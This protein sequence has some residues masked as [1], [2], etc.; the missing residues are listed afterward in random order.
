MPMPGPLRLRALEFLPRT[1][2][3]LLARNDF[4]RPVVITVA[5]VRK[6]KMTIHQVADV[7]AVGHS[8]VAAVGT[9]DVASFVTFAVVSRRA[10]GGIGFIDLQGM[11]FDGTTALVVEMS[12]VKI[13][14]MI[15]VTNGG[16]AAVL[17][18][19]VIVIFVTVTHDFLTSVRVLE[20][21]RGPSAPDRRHAD[22]GGNSKCAFP[23]VAAQSS[24]RC[25]IP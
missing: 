10:S 11:L 18:V 21:A 6:V 13:I 2:R 14:D 22:P 7:V 24:A 17:A 19:L 1:G 25:A 16:V 9:V 20:R 23:A 4:H 5:V 15:A 3:L 8:L 12:I